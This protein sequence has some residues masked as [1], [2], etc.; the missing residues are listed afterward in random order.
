MDKKTIE[1]YN[2]MALEYDAQTVDFWERF[3]RTFLDEFVSQVGVG[4]RVLDVEVGPL[5][6]LIGVPGLGVVGGVALGD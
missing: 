3:P 4:K 1:A 6:V 5:F 2:K